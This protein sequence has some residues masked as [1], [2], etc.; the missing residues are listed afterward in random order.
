MTSDGQSVA[1][2]IK[3]TWSDLKRCIMKYGLRNSLLIAL[4]PTASTAQVRRNCE[5]VEAHQNNLYSRNV[6]KCSYPVLN[7]YLL[8]DLEE[9]GVWNSHTVEF[10]KVKNG[11]IQ[12][13]SKFL[14]ENPSLFPNF[15]GDFSRMSHV[16]QKYKT[17]WEISQ[18]VF[19]KLAAD[20][21]RYV[22]QSQ[23]TN[24]YISDCTDTKLKACH[25]Y[26]KQLCI[27]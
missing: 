20:R 12:G 16:E 9:L 17:M 7:R 6:L 13:Y 27:I 23:S 8:H 4:M 1:D 22:D 14:K 24:I 5:S 15:T 3:P 21:G 18:K 25:L 26:S 11:S 2:V 10:L 19:L